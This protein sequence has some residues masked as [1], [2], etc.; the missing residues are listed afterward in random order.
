MGHKDNVNS[1]QF[2]PDG[3][4][5][6]TASRDKTAQLWDAASG[7]AIGEPMKHK[8]N[9]VSAQFS[10][11]GQRVVTA[12]YD[13]T[14]RLWNAASG[15]PIG[16][17][18]K[19]NGFVESAQFSPDGQRVVTASYDNTARLWDAATGKPIGEPM[20]HNNV[21]NSA[22]FSP[23]SKRVVTASFDNT[24]QLW[25]AT[26]GKPIGGPMKHH[27]TVFSAQFSPDGQLV[28]TASFDKTARLWDAGSSRPI[29][30]PMEHK[31]RVNSARFSPDGQRV[32]TASW[33][34]TAQVWD[35]ASMTNKDT[36]ENILLLAELAE[37]TA[38]VT[39]ETVGQGENFTMLTPEQRQA[40]REKI[41][42]KFLQ[43][44]SKLTPLQRVMKWSVADRRSRTISP[45]SQETVSE[46]LEN[47]IKEGTVEGLRAALEVDPANARVTA[48]LGRRLA[49]QALKQG[50]DPDKARRA[51]GEADFLTSRA[52]K[53]APDNE[54]VKKLRDEVVKV[55]SSTPVE[56][57]LAAVTPA[58][59]LVPTP[60]NSLTPPSPLPLGPKRYHLA[61]VILEVNDSTIAVQKGNDRWELARDSNTNIRGDL[62]IGAK[63]TVTYVM[64]ASGVGPSGSFH[65][66]RNDGPKAYQATGAVMEVNESMIAL[67]KQTARWEVARNSN[68]N[69]RGDLK[70]GANVTITYTM[71]ATDMEVKPESSN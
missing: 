63:V 31:D 62:K 42:A 59:T 6:V 35:G 65:G 67:Q 27:G 64:T 34:N 15:K 5:V 58:P 13:E 68:T 28:V 61:G 20:K 8:D 23:D 14:A 71:T 17:S 19:H 32:V 30:E 43:P 33:D 57:T 11:D 12:S 3:Q 10:L 54:E 50:S 44:S 40:T 38:G 53:L 24:A 41:A 2:S 48:H 9:V 39:L 47:R 25:D 60:V 51:R 1:A 18:M 56:L 16:K 37:A 29:G 46:W 26:S 69:I 4:R 52:Q 36:T 55:G 45:L 7:K 22:Q 49:D 66:L 70:I 21:V